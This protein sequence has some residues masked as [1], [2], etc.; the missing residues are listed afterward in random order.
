MKKVF[1]LIVL[2]SVCSQLVKAQKKEDALK[3]YYLVLLKKGPHRDQ[4]SVTAAKI[5][6]EH[7]ENINRLAAAG[8]LN[9]AGPF[10]DDGDLRGIFIFGRHSSGIGDVGRPDPCAHARAGG[11]RARNDQP[12]LQPG[13]IPQPSFGHRRGR[14]Q[15][16]L[17]PHVVSAAGDQRDHLPLRTGDSRGRASHR[18]PSRLKRRAGASGNPLP[19][20]RPAR[21]GL[22]KTH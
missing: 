3:P 17:G 20:P 22:E 11:N 4:D 7:L 6:K 21:Q 8:K 14:R 19:V 5:Q 1:T 9:V 12:G 13:P 2:L 16:C 10:L 18:Q 15:P